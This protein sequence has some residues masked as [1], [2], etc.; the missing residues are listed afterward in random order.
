M[1]IVFWKISKLFLYCHFAGWN[2]Q[3][4][5]YIICLSVLAFWMVKIERAK[6]WTI[7]KSSYICCN[8]RKKSKIKNIFFFYYMQ[9][10]TIKQKFYCFLQVFFLCF[11]R[12]VLIKPQ[13]M[14]ICLHL[15]QNLQNQKSGYVF[16]FTLNPQKIFIFFITSINPQ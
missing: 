7:K 1:S 15:R 5:I 9:R 10:L 2:S 8:S 11:Y 12:L 13:Y 3:T 4:Y 16:T 6:N 14:G